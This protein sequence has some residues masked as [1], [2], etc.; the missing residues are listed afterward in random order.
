MSGGRHVWIRIGCAVDK[1]SCSNQKHVYVTYMVPTSNA[2]TYNPGEAYK[3]EKNIQKSHFLKLHASLFYA[4]RRMHIYLQ[5][6]GL[7]KNIVFEIIRSNGT[8]K[9][10]TNTVIHLPWICI[11]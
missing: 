10:E 1:K 11:G 9:N 7:L 4:P 5:N 6:L 3:N 2:C 8:Y